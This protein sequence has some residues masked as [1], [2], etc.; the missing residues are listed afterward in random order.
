MNAEVSADMEGRLPSRT[1]A[2][3][4][5]ESKMKRLYEAD[6]QLLSAIADTA[7]KKEME[8]SMAGCQVQTQTCMCLC[9]HLS[10][11][12]STCL[13]I[14]I[15]FTHC[16]HPSSIY[17]HRVKGLG[18]VRQRQVVS[19][20]YRRVYPRTARLHC[21]WHKRISLSLAFSLSP[22]FPLPLSFSHTQV[23]VRA[24]YVADGAHSVGRRTTMRHASSSR[25]RRLS[26][27][28]QCQPVGDTTRKSGMPAVQTDA[29]GW[30]CVSRFN[31]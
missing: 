7:R 15:L 10:R 8:C 21:A 19:G 27:S 26:E 31:D 17:P 11:C 14:Q 9:I 25:P 3:G 23:Q 4:A 13:P 22:P 20:Q 24:V 5:A 6:V 1:N 2:A 28:R 16:I 18:G 12:I 29:Q 30:I